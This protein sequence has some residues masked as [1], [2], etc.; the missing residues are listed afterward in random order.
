M[1]NKITIPRSSEELTMLH[2]ADVLEGITESRE[3]YR[4]IVRALIAQGVKSL[5]NGNMVIESIAD[6]ERLIKLDLE[7][8]KDKFIL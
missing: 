4:K 1:A 2:N 5:Q 3:S 8:Q 6:L 7:L